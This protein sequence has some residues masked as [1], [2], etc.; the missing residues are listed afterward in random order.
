MHS[1]GS[2]PFRLITAVI[3][4]T[5]LAGCSGSET[6][7]TPSPAGSSGSAAA[8]DTLNLAGATVNRDGVNSEFAFGIDQRVYDDFVTA[9]AGAIRTIEWQGIRRVAATPTQFRLQIIADGAAP[10][11]GVLYETVYLANQVNERLDGAQA[12]H[13]LPQQQCGLYSYSVSLATP[14]ASANGSRYW[15]MVQ[16]ETPI[17][18]VHP[19]DS[20]GSGWSWRKGTLDNGYSKSTIANTIFTWD[21]AFAIR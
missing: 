18:P 5:L 3:L 11:A 4:S 21:F 16:A 10:G 6:G 13:N 14:F 8:H 19:F 15:L 9:K 7:T 1:S 2:F 20:V 17:D 12:C